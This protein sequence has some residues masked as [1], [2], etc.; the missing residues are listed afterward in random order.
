MMG[1][2]VSK[3]ESAGYVGKTALLEV[4]TDNNSRDENVCN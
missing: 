1:K 3:A 2:L 4:P